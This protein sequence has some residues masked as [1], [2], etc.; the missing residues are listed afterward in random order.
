MK[1]GRPRIEK[2]LVGSSTVMD[3]KWRRFSAFLQRSWGGGNEN[4]N[5]SDALN[6]NNTENLGPGLSKGYEKK[7]RRP[8]R[9]KESESLHRRFH[10]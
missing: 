7:N 6:I 4:E 8:K 5:A 3:Y 10:L 2:K 1:G 9:G